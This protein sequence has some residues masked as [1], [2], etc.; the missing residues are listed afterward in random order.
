MS[1]W[2]LKEC[3]KC[4]GDLYLDPLISG[5][6]VKCLQCGLEVKLSFLFI[7]GKP[8]RQVNQDAKNSEVVS[9]NRKEPQ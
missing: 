2:F 3:P 1:T 9:T 6:F 5:D 8:V 4:G 7:G